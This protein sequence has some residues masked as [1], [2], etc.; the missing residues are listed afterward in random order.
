MF[1]PPSEYHTAPMDAEGGGGGD[2]SFF[3]TCKTPLS[4]LCVSTEQNHEL[5]LHG[6]YHLLS[7]PRSRGGGGGGGSS[8]KNHTVNVVCSIDLTQLLVHE[9]GSTRLSFYSLPTLH[10]NRYHL[11]AV[12]ALHTS[13][14]SHLAALQQSI[15]DVANSWNSS[16][17]PLNDKLAPLQRLLSNYGV[18][19]PEGA[20]FR[21]YILI[22]HTSASSNMANA[23]DQFFT[24]VQMNDQLLQRMERSLQGGLA[25]VETMIRKCLVSPARAMVYH[26][27]ELVGE[28]R[29]QTADHHYNDSSS[30]NDNN[31]NSESEI[32]TLQQASEMLLLSA[33][34]LLTHFIESRFRLRDFVAWL[35][36]TGSQIKA[37]GTAN[38]SVQ[39]DNA[40]KRRV[41]EAVMQRVLSS[42]EAGASRKERDTDKQSRNDNL[43]ERLLGMKISVRGKP[44][45]MHH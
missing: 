26:V 17:K 4:L 36:S 31:N 3:P 22:G 45:K 13:I 9:R 10:Q 19:E 30:S 2:T 18:D 39:R 23:M 32:V 25:N 27:G 28:I 1:L 7:L 44:S 33:E 12:T 42:L 15:P 40:K 16:V 11:Q 21:Q 38:Q 41:S 14:T 35:R 29:F 34:T 8:D 37:R 24:G 5:Y 20:V 43:T 6:R